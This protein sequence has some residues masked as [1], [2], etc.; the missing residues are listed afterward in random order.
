MEGDVSRHV[1]KTRRTP[2][3]LAEVGG[4]RYRSGYTTQPDKLDKSQEHEIPRSF[5]KMPTL[6]GMPT[7]TIQ[8]KRKDAGSGREFGLLS[9]R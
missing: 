5:E 1:S 3:D 7:P 2:T 4:E 9:P 8:K 6:V